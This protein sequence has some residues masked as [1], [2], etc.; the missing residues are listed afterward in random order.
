MMLTKFESL[1]FLI[2]EVLLYAIDNNNNDEGS[3][4]QEGSQTAIN[5]IESEHSKQW[6]HKQK[7]QTRANKPS[8]EYRAHRYL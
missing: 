1:N 5:K 8:K 4:K 2:N 6:V 3:K 7:P